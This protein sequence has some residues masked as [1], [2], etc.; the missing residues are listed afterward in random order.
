MGFTLVIIYGLDYSRAVDSGDNTEQDIG[1]ISLGT[2]AII[3][4]FL[5]ALRLPESVRQ[6][7]GGKVMQSATS[8]IGFYGVMPDPHWVANS[9]RLASVDNRPPL[10]KGHG[11]FTLVDT[12]SL[13]VS[14]FSAVRPPSVALICGRKGGMLRTVLYYYERSNNCLYKETVMP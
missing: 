2:L 5:L 11:F 13:T 6:L 3:F 12:G 14:I 9:G 8:L 1:L 7:Y 4:P 10:L